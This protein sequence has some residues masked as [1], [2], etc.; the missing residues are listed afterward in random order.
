MF[1]RLKQSTFMNYQNTG[2]KK[3]DSLQGSNEGKSVD[4][5]RGMFNR[6]GKMLLNNSFDKT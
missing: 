3:G 4:G 1:N 5:S 2:Q 6:V